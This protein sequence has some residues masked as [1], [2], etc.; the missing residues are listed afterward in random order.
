MAILKPQQLSASNIMAKAHENIQNMQPIAQNIQTAAKDGY[1][2][3]RLIL[4]RYPS[5]RVS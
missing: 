1:D 4:D 3:F 2:K 5:L